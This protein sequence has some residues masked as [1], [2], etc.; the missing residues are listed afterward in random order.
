MAI[1][2][3]VFVTAS[4]GAFAIVAASTAHAAPGFGPSNRLGSQSSTSSSEGKSVSSDSLIDMLQRFVH[5]TLDPPKPY[6]GLTGT[7]AS[8]VKADKKKNRKDC[9]EKKQ[10]E[11][12]EKEE[13]AAAV[14]GPEP[15]YFGF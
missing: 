2:K 14:S 12:E 9:P 4:V 1:Q 3:S 13:A 7:D 8:T 6:L 5:E 11:A 10:S 15:I